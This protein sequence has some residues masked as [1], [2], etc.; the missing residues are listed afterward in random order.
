MEMPQFTIAID[1]PSAAGKSTIAKLI[2]Q[3]TG[4]L[5]LDTG[6]MYRALGL[7]ALR[8]SVSLAD[9]PAVMQVLEDAN[10]SVRYEGGEQRI[11]LGCEDVSAKIREPKVSDAASAVSAIAQVRAQMVCR[12]QQ[13]AAGQSCVLDGRDIG[14]K[15][16]P[17]AT[18]KIF[19][20]ADPKVRA[21]RRHLELVGRGGHDTYEDVLA[22]M[23]RRDHDDSTRSASPLTKAEDAVEIDATHMT[24]VAVAEKVIELLEE[25]IGG[26]V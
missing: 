12:Q 9:I 10:I 19:L 18:L 20:I 24:A 25:R 5:Y 22:Q 17:D 2:S 4:A 14:T 6:A 7:C 8:N 26:M 16:L 15:V 11:Y 3:R 23:I 13:I 21:Q 1:G